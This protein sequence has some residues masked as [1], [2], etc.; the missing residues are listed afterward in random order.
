M[1]TSK[2][3]I[4]FD[5][6]SD[7]DDSI[8]SFDF[9]VVN[10]LENVENLSG[11]PEEHHTLSF[12]AY[13]IGLKKLYSKS[14]TRKYFEIK[15]NYLSYDRVDLPKCEDLKKW[16]NECFDD[17]LTNYYFRLPEGYQLITRSIFEN[18]LNSNKS[19]LDMLVY[20]IVNNKREFFKLLTR[21]ELMKLFV[22]KKITELVE[23]YMNSESFEN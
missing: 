18:F 16:L 13:G 14:V 10:E 23:N 6:S 3:L 22:D 8:E 20:Q 12:I 9:D 15:K 1:G 4:S 7:D 19:K 2:Y 5:D 21:G 11:I 17:T